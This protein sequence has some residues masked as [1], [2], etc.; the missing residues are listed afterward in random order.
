[1]FVL[2]MLINPV[3]SVDYVAAV[4]TIL[5]GTPGFARDPAD[6]A[7]NF[8]DIAGT[9]PVST[10]GV[11]T[12]ARANT[13]FGT[14]TYNLQQAAATSQPL[15]N[16]A[17]MQVDGTD[18][19]VQTTNAT[20]PNAMTALS[21]TRRFNIT[22]FGLA[23]GIIGLSTAGTTPI[24]L[25]LRINIDGSILLALRRL[26]TDAQQSFTTA[27]GLVSA[28]ISYTVQFTINY[29]TGAVEIFL[30]GVSVLTGT[31]TGTDGINGVSATNSARWRDGL[32]P[33]N[34]LNDWFKGKLGCEVAAVNQV[35]DLTALANCRGY[36]E[37]N[38]L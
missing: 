4:T 25:L 28:G 34:T 33:T 18:D 14:S 30:N 15:W 24:R 9:V 38:A 17:S 35:L 26:D 21:Y 11:S 7:S 20:W 2:P 16:G 1:M 23:R 8:T 29:L 37:R 31:Y 32:N 10:P 22:D 19:L 12:I 5:S 27:T 3:T 36:V 6:T 13:L